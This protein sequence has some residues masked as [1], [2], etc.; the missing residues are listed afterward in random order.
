[1]KLLP[2]ALAVSCATLSQIASAQENSRP[3]LETVTIIGSTNSYE[4]LQSITSL[5]M[6]ELNRNEALWLPDALK[7]MP[8]VDIMG[9]NNSPTSRN[10][11]IRGL[12]RQYIAI[13]IDGARNNFNA[14]KSG[15]FTQPMNLLKQV[16]VIRGPSSGAGGGLIRMTTK[17]AADLLLPGESFGGQVQLGSRS[18]NGAET[19]ALSLFATQG[20][21]DALVSGARTTTQNL[22][23]GGGKESPQSEIHTSSSLVK[24]GYDISPLQNI[25]ISHTA[26]AGTDKRTRE[27]TENRERFS[28]NLVLGH[29]WQGQSPLLDLESRI[30]QNKSHHKVLD[31]ATGNLA[32]DIHLTKGLSLTNHA[33][34]P[35]GVASIGIEYYE[36]SIEPKAREDGTSGSDPTKSPAGE[37]KTSA[38]FALYDFA[39][40]NTISVLPSLR[41]DQISMQSDDAVD[42]DGDPVGRKAESKTQLSKGLRISW[43]VSDELTTHASYSEALV[44]P[45]LSELYVSGRGFEPNPNLK[46][47]QAQNKEIGLTWSVGQIFGKG[48]NSLKVNVFDNEL[49]NYIGKQYTNSEY[50]DGS[51]ANLDSVR[52]HGFEISDSYVQGALAFDA[53]YGQTVGFDTKQKE[54]LFDMPSDKF[55]FSVEWAMQNNLT[56]QLVL[57][58]AVALTRV[59]VSG[60]YAEGRGE[61]VQYGTLPEEY[62]QT[63]AAWTTVDLNFNYQPKSTENLAL[64]VGITNLTDRAYA[65]RN[66]SEEVDV[67]Y[68]EEGRSV[69]MNI[70]YNFQKIKYSG[71]GRSIL[72]MVVQIFPPG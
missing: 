47:V 15:S 56:S 16:D 54:F 66:Y 49:K 5:D 37:L 48:Q 62:D 58:H 43:Q 20:K 30:Y 27:E 28:N 57:N 71:P 17:S 9:D 42:V 8:N 24:L 6:S 46:P 44:A 38:I 33:V 19:A 61:P 50:K 18:N 36:D 55:K 14:V 64:N 7:K 10:I 22:K 34:I 69:N 3:E 40:T 72:K 65:S 21:W 68:Y 29:N 31:S 70:A 63:T 1:M 13:T 60:W 12:D 67:K 4:S 25:F 32:E 52:I 45:R 41:F 59:P 26:S 2:L 53:S 11:T 51:Y 23:I 35:G 39:L